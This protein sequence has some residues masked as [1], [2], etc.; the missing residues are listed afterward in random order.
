MIRTA[1]LVDMTA[2]VNLI[3]TALVDLTGLHSVHEGIII[4]SLTGHN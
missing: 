2:L 1:L 3:R 4:E